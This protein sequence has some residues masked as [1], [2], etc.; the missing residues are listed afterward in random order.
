VL[1]AGTLE[2]ASA[3]SAPKSGIEN[4]V[5]LRGAF[6]DGSQAPISNVNP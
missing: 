4:V 2:S 5:L 3:Q 1:A 6:A